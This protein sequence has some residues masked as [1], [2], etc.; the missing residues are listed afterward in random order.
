MIYIIGIELQVVI[1]MVADIEKI[2]IDNII[3]IISEGNMIMIH[4]IT[5]CKNKVIIIIDKINIAQHLTIENSINKLLRI[6]IKFIKRID[7]ININ[8]LFQFK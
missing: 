6:N 3:K 7:K 2:E 5:N 8:I 1:I 4:V